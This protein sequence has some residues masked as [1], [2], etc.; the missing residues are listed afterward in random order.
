MRKS[1]V[2]RIKLGTVFEPFTWNLLGHFW[3]F[4]GIHLPTVS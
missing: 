2:K 4:L 3:S 1:E